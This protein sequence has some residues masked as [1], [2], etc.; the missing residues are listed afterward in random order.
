MKYRKLGN[1]GLDVSVI[2]F[3]FW[4]NQCSSFEENKQLVAMCLKNGINYFD[5]AQAYNNG[6]NEEDLGKIFQQLN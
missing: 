3:G 2:S 6:K 1:S 5:T 4:T